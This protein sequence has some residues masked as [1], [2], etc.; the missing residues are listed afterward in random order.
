M[1]SSSARGTVY[2]CP[3]C[4]AELSVLASQHGDFFPRCCNKPMESL[5]RRLVFFVCPVCGAEI[6]I[7]NEGSGD[8]Q[9]RCCNTA[10]LR[11]AA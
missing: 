10:M 11:E 3:V 5:R 6:G 8:F 4:G 7:V 9:P 2:W 1:R